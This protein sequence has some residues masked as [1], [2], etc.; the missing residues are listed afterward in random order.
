MSYEELR[1]LFIKLTEYPIKNNEV[2]QQVHRNIWNIIVPRC[3]DLVGTI[4]AG[5]VCKCQIL[6]LLP[7]FPCRTEG[8]KLL[9]FIGHASKGET[10]INYGHLYQFIA[11]LAWLLFN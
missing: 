11:G 7:D 9:V 2:L 4:E 5:E 3:P 10:A 6:R 1:R 8:C